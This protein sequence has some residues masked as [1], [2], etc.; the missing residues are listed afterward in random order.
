MC[1][2]QDS[3]F[4]LAATAVGSMAVPDDEGWDGLPRGIDD[5]LPRSKARCEV[6]LEESSHDPG[7]G[8]E[9]RGWVP[10]AHASAHLAIIHDTSVLGLFARDAV[11]GFGGH[12]VRAVGRHGDI[13]Q[14]HVRHEA[15]SEA[16]P[17]ENAAALA[18]RGRSGVEICLRR[19]FREVSSQPV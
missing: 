5:V 1:V 15:V 12:V 17:G 19:L 18:L 16:D 4:A 6:R 11:E 13:L 3:Y 14:G 8:A 2:A 9:I 7:T 10:Q